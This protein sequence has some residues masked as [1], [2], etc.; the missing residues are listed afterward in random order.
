MAV[1]HDFIKDLPAD[2]AHT[3]KCI[4]AHWGIENNLHWVLDVIF[5]EDN[6]LL[7]NDNIVQNEAIIRRCALNVIRRYKTRYESNMAIKTIRKLLIG[8][9]VE[10]EKILRE[11]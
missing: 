11:F 1:L 6:R 8:D 5:R 4:G 7:W 9:D 10:M 2:A 3:L